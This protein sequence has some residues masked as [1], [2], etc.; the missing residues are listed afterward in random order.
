MFVRSPS[1][2]SPAGSVVRSLA[3]GALSPVSAASWSSSVADVTMRPSAGTTSP[4]SSSTT[5]PGTRS[6]DVDLLDPAR[7]AHPGVRHLELGQ[8]LDAG[9]RLQ[10]LARAHDHVE[11]HERRDDHAGED[12]A[13]AKL[14]TATTISMMFIGLA[15]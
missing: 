14:A 13:D 12:L 3:T 15:S 9:P 4:A 10:L 6:I 1:A 2:V 5:S 7:S 11:G 8:R